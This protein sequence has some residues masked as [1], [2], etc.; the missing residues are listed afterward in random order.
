MEDWKA[1][2]VRSYDEYWRLYDE[3]FAEHFRLRVVAEANSF[4]ANLQGRQIL[5]L[6]S[7]PGVHA[8]FFRSRGF[9]VM[10]VDLS[11]A[12]VGLCLRRGLRAEVADMEMLDYK[13]DSFDGVWAY[14]SLLH[15]PKNRIPGM[16]SKIRSWLRPDGLLSMSFKE[17]TS[18]GLEG[19]E[20]F[21]GTR[22]WFT[23]VEAEEVMD[24]CADGFVPIRCS[25]V[26]ASKRSTFMNFTFMKNS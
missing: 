19:H 1:E 23:Y 7:G 17:G 5:D 3:R 20:R 22:R 13:P 9:N 4:L 16:I 6:G 15:L 26:Q 21:P 24:W 2:T 25:A 12:M 14:A 10:C 11:P 8:E 18:Q